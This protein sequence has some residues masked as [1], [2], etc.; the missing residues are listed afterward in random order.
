MRRWSLVL[1]LLASA[2]ASPAPPVA[3]PT[4][5]GLPV[6]LVPGYGGDASSVSHLA[7]ALRQ[8]GRD[9]HVVVTQDGG[10]ARMSDGAKALDAAVAASHATSVDL[11]GVSA[12]GVV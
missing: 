10:T 4:T 9:V 6:F 1:L 3:S 12:G 8:A 7:D 11:G 5:T 2:C